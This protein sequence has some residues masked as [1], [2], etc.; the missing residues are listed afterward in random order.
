MLRLPLARKNTSRYTVLLWLAGL[1]YGQSGFG[2]VC[3][4]LAKE[5]AVNQSFGRADAPVSLVGRTTYQNTTDLCPLDGS[6]KVADAVDGSCFFSLWHG[7]PE[8]HTP[9]DVRGNMMIVNGSDEPGSFYEHPLSGLCSGTAYEFSVWGMNLLKPGICTAP[10]L[11]DLTISV[12]TAGGQVIQSIHIGTIPQSVTPTWLQYKAVFT[13]P[14]IT[15]GVVVKLINRQGS[16]GCGNDL[17]LDD[18]QLKQCGACSPTPL[19]V[20]EAFSPNNDGVNDNLA[21]FLRR[22]D[23][24]SLTIYN[25]WGS[26]VF[27]STALNQ[28]WDGKHNGTPCPAG[29]YTWVIN[30]QLADATNVTRTYSKSGRVLL[31]R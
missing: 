28:Q 3:L 23:S 4:D 20:P 31:L 26:P 5:P 18:I 16:G 29:D 22:A 13:A 10:L 9:N 17:A 6:Y 25:R 15:D 2:Q 27:V 21:V 11:P 14:E 12:E 7:V 24:F 30:Y 8:D 19:Y 1:L